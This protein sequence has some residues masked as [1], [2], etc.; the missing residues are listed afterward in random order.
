MEATK[1][2]SYS[3]EE[4]MAPRDTFTVFASFGHLLD[5]GEMLWSFWGKENLPEFKK[6]IWGMKII[7]VC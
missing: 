5:K 7:F 3:Q 4:P 6:S 1:S 2:L